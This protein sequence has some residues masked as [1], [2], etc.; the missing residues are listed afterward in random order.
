MIEDR[1]LDTW[2]EQWGSGGE[3][4]PEFR[5][6]I[7]QKI[8]RQSLRFLFGNLLTAIALVGIL[9]FAVFIPPSLTGDWPSFHAV[10]PQKK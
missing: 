7:Q 5:R 6:K 9:I 1:E 4:P 2:R 8:K 10:Y 3:P